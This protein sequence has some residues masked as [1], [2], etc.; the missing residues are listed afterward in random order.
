MG[1][2]GC[3]LY[4]DAEVPGP[5]ESTAPEAGSLVETG[6]SFLVEIQIPQFLK[7]LLKKLLC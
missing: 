7:R 6:T 1:A 5:L 4:L 3:I 2:H